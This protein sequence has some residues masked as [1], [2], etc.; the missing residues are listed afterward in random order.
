MLAEARGGEREAW[1]RL[2]RETYDELKRLAHYQLE[3]GLTMPTLNTTSLVS[4]W[5]LRLCESGSAVPND[6][7]HFFALA[8]KIMRQVI[9]GY[10]RERLTAKRGAGQA[11]FDL[12]AVE[13]QVLDEAKQFVGLDQA[14][15]RLGE[16]D[17][18]LVRVVE[19]RYFAG[20]TESETAEAMNCSVRSVQR[21]WASARERLAR[22]LEA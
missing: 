6:R 18:D 21:T 12:D 11:R 14:L 4:E 17:A 8:S 19:C 1:A 2:L 15:V 10:A 3:R 5:Y 22:E 20:M 9:C 16:E 7:R 13:H